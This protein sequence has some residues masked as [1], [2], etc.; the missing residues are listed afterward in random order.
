MGSRGPMMMDNDKVG[1]L[2]DKSDNR[3]YRTHY[4]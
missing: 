1:M 3:G 2:L 4:A